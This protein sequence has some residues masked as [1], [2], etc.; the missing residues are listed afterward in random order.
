VIDEFKAFVREEARQYEKEFPDE[1]YEE[2]YRLYGLNRPEKGRPIRF[3]QLTNMQIY[4]PLAKSKGKILEQ[5][6]ASRDENGKQSD[7]LHLFLSEI[8]VKAL[9]QHIGK[10]LGVAAMSETREEYEKGIEKVFGR[11]KPEI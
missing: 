2:W 8:G 7:K 6:R 4:T 5:I 11:M 1:L 10:L 9:R 3:G